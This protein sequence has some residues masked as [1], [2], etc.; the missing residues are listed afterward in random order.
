MN[1]SH[2]YA[3][4][5]LAVACGIALLTTGQAHAGGY[6]IPEQ[7]V[8]STALSAAYVANAHGADSAYFNPAA[9]V[10][11]DEQAT[12]E[13]DLSWIHL[14]SVSAYIDNVQVDSSEQENFLMPDFH[15]V[16][17]PMGNARFGISVTSP[18]GLSK[19]WLGPGKG[20]AEEFT[21]KAVEINPSIAYK[22]NDQF[23]IAAGARA[24]IS[25]GIVKSTAT[26]ASRD[27]DGEWGVDYGYNLA[28][29][30]K[31]TDALSLAATYRSK[32]NLTEEGTALLTDISSNT[33]NGDASVN[34]PAP[35][36]INLAAA[37][38]FNEKTTVELVLERTKWSAYQALDFNYPTTLPS[39]ILIGAM[40]NPSIK[41]WKDSDTVRIGLTHQ[42]D[43]RWTLMAGFALDETP[44]NKKRIGYELPD[45]DAKIYSFGARYKYS[46][47]LSIGGAFLYDDKDT[48]TFT[49][50]DG[51]SSFND[52][53]YFKDSAAYFL[54]VGMEYK[55]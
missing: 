55:F 19:R 10:F 13:V 16:G 5:P 41:E 46:D 45:S 20:T 11:N 27:M 24:I 33:Y 1:R 36:S 53:D 51:N 32:I 17:T 49:N 47:R 14:T 8:N 37:Y 25:K 48:L 4:N 39:A 43:S 6:K 50:A 15:Y 38:T 35:A 18:V 44:A 7:S 3:L 26:L 54:T 31:P 21:L 52:N 9:M 28:L 23:S 12:M 40:D 30:Y 22:V 2:K 29:L 34:I 42:L